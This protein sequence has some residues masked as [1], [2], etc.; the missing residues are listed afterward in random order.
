MDQNRHDPSRRRSA[1]LNSAEL[2]FARHGYDRA[3]VAAVAK[4]AEYPLSVVYRTFPGGKIQI[5]NE[6]NDDRFDELVKFVLPSAGDEMPP[7]RRMID[8]IRAAYIFMCRH[9]NFLELHLREGFS[10]ATA[11]DSGRG[12]QRRS[13]AAAV[14]IFVDMAAADGG[15]ATS[16]HFSA[17]RIAR[18][19]ISI[20]QVWLYE[21]WHGPRD[22]A[23]EEDAERLVSFLSLWLRDED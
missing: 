1:I 4:R 9:P 18:L 22:S 11:T 20:V 10:W 8:S 16:A 3:K 21:W 19:A 13:W 12:S 15:A 7:A 17:T 2:E 23:I 5:W 6:L 14:D